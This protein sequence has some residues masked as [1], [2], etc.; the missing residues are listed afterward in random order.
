M[1]TSQGLNL[2]RSEHDETRRKEEQDEDEEEEEEEEEIIGKETALDGWLLVSVSPRLHA[3]PRPGP[4]NDTDS[5][6][7]LYESVFCRNGRWPLELRQSQINE[8]LLVRRRRQNA[9]RLISHKVERRRARCGREIISRALVKAPFT[10]P[11]MEEWNNGVIYLFF[12][13]KYAFTARDMSHGGKET[14]N[15][16]LFKSTVLDYLDCSVLLWSLS[17]DKMCSRHFSSLHREPRPR[18]SSY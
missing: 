14:R 4:I 11:S 17:W 16:S 5:V 10:L 13:L 8:T 9:P 7:L 18:E 3:G 12:I 15:L 6:C 1:G 2:L